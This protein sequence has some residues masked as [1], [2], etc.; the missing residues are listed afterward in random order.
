M[1]DHRNHKKKLI[2]SYKNLPDPVKE[3]FKEAYPEGYRAYIQKT[4]KPNG[5]PIFVVPLETDDTS[6]MV[7]FDVVYDT[8]MVEE[9]V[10]KDNY[11]DEE[12]GEATMVPLQEAVDKDEGVDNHQVS[13]LNHAAYDEMF[14][15]L[16]EDKEEFA[17]DEDFDEYADKPDDEGD[18]YVDDIDSDPDD[19]EPDDEELL[20]IENMMNATIDENGMLREVEA[21]ENDKQKKKKKETRTQKAIKDIQAER[22]KASKTTASKTP[23]AAK[24]A[25]KQAKPAE[26]QAKP[27]KP[28]KETKAEK[29]VKAAVAKKT[30]KTT[31]K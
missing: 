18:S 20:N 15:G 6:Y 11:D 27:A 9:D 17:D 26:K 10:D 16:P 1:I 22:V 29:P 28:A 2:I 19:I 31:K 25:E 12:Q 13:V 5:E 30:T 3:L 21:V 4:I 7:K 24:P 14:E 23:K 8:T